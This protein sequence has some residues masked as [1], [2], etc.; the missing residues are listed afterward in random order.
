MNK[1]GFGNNNNTPGNSAPRVARERIK[2]VNKNNS[3]TN[4]AGQSVVIGYKIRLNENNESVVRAADSV[5][6]V[7]SVGGIIA[8]ETGYINGPTI[9][10]LGS[11]IQDKLVNAGSTDPNFAGQ[12]VVYLLPVFLDRYQQNVYVQTDNVDYI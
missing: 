5:F 3:V 7:D 6:A 10:T 1:F 4:A 11:F 9:K 2:V 8:G 12:E